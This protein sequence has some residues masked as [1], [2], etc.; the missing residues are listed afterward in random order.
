MPVPLHGALTP[1]ERLHQH[2]G[3]TQG[4]SALLLNRGTLGSGI[5]D[6]GEHGRTSSSRD[7]DRIVSLAE[8]SGVW[9]LWTAG[10]AS[11]TAQGRRRGGGASRRPQGAVRRGTGTGGRPWPAHGGRFEVDEQERVVRRSTLAAAAPAALG[12]GVGGAWGGDPR[13]QTP[14]TPAA[15][16]HQG[17]GGGGSWGRRPFPTIWPSKA[18]R[19][20]G[21]LL[22]RSQIA[23]AGD[24]FFFY[25]KKN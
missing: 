21:R 25:I 22:G 12:T 14:A 6:S 20:M 4:R 15:A 8:S 1:N 19:Q 5:F 18:A 16:L 24:F 17:A 7:P 23:P 11:T 10:R 2:H 13:S 3:R 9:R